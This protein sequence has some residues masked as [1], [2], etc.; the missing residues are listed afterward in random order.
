MMTRWNDD[1]DEFVKFARCWLQQREGS[2][3]EFRLLLIGDGRAIRNERIVQSSGGSDL[4]R[5]VSSFAA[6][7]GR[8]GEYVQAMD[9]WGEMVIRVGVATARSSLMTASAAAA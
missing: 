8:D 5:S 6:N 3:A 4:W 1:F 2:V 7:Y 9:E